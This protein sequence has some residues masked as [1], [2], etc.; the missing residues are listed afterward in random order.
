MFFIFPI[1]LLV[2]NG[3]NGGWTSLQWEIF[4][5]MCYQT[6]CWFLFILNL[7][8]LLLNRI[9]CG[10]FA[11]FVAVLRDQADR[12]HQEQYHVGTV[13]EANSSPGKTT[14]PGKF[15]ALM[16]ILNS[17]DFPLVMP[18]IC[19]SDHLGSSGLDGLC[20]DWVWEDSSIS[21][22]HPEPNLWKGTIK[23][24]SWG[25]KFDLDPICVNFLT[26]SS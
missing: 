16:L 10:S 18:E 22:S 8:S 25:C 13:W 26:F 19:N 3:K 17:N 15:S 14:F 2:F 6:L 1:I 7:M 4:C 11:L 20:P 5:R 23:Q 9:S 21:C 24:Q 12:N